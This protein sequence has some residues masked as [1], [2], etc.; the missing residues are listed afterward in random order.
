M[1][2]EKKSKTQKVNRQTDGLI[3]TTEEEQLTA[4]YCK[5]ADL[6]T[7]KKGKGGPHLIMKLMATDSGFLKLG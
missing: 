7:D 1:V 6:C 4:G 3:Y 5:S 2:L